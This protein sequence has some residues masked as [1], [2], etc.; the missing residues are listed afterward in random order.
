M[1]IGER[2]GKAENSYS[3]GGIPSRGDPFNPHVL[4]PQ[5]VAAQITSRPNSGGR[6]GWL[7]CWINHKKHDSHN[8]A[9]HNERQVLPSDLRTLGA[10]L[11]WKSMCNISDL[12]PFA[13]R[14]LVEGEC[15]DS[16][17]NPG[18]FPVPERIC[19]FMTSLFL[20][21]SVVPTDCQWAEG[22][23]YEQTNDRICERVGNW[24]REWPSVDC[25]RSCGQFGFC[26]LP[27]WRTWAIGEVVT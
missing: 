17:P 6:S 25:T 19:L 15:H 5:S 8:L 27:R 26:P 14:I 18:N 12:S 3:N 7:K 22:A 21:R 24:S 2:V 13:S 23:H 16:L 4:Q 10:N 20:R 11:S 9:P 1:W